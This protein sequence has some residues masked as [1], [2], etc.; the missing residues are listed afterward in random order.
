MTQIKDQG[1]LRETSCSEELFA[2]RDSL[3]ILGGKWKLLI[4]IYL[5]NRQDQLVHFKM[6]ERGIQGISAKMLSKE[7]KELEINELVTRTIQDTR[8]ITVTYALTDYGKSVIPVIEALVQWGF[9][10]RMMIKKTR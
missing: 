8:P 1:I 3:E 5:K 7:L 2:I 6:I 9:D 10:H 4:L